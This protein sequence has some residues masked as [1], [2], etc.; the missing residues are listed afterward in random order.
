MTGNTVFQYFRKL[1][2]IELNYTCLNSDFF[3]QSTFTSL[4]YKPLWGLIFD[5]FLNRP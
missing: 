4:T 3:I 5:Q 2:Y 1:S